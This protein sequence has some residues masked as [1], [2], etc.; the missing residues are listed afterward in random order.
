MELYFT[1][2]ALFCFL[3]IGNVG[4]HFY[5][6]R[7]HKKLLEFLNRKDYVLIQNISTNIE[8]SSN[9]FVYNQVNKANVIFFKDHI[10]LLTTSKIC[11]I[12][13]PTLQINRIGNN[14]N[15]LLFGKK[16]IIF[17]KIRLKINFV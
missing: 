7:K 12:G 13:Q 14:E 6:K 9:K 3:M 5:N 16:S 2:V 10:F 11:K 8:V 17:Q 1:I 15:L 4:T